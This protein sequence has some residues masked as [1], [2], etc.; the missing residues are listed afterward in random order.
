MTTSEITRQ[1]NRIF[2]ALVGLATIAILLQGVWAGLFIRSGQANDRHW[3]QV[4]ARGADLT[5]LLAVL[6]FAFALW[7][8]RGRR[9]LVIGSAGLVVLVGLE[10]F[11]GGLVVHHEVLEVIH[12]PLALAL[13]GLAVWLPLRARH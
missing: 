7:R 13:M 8:L 9:D 1:P 6:A 12:F 2:S 4:H 5:L 11:I 10:A 3:V